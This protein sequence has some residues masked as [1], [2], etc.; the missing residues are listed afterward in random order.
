M[1]LFTKVLVRFPLQFIS[2]CCSVIWCAGLDVWRLQ[3]NAWLYQWRLFDLREVTQVHEF[4]F[5]HLQSADNNTFPANSTGQG[6]G[7]GEITYESVSETTKHSIMQG[8]SHLPS[9]RSLVFGPSIFF[10]KFFMK[11]SF[12]EVMFACIGF[13]FCF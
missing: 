9:D 4:H 3:F 12:I 6:E 13:Y 2:L 1:D 5:S 11:K 8:V 7:S 10:N